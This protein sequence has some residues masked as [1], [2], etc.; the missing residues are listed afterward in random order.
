MRKFFTII[1]LWIITV[2]S[3]WGYEKQLEGQVYSDE[4]PFEICWVYDSTRS[5]R[6]ST[7]FREAIVVYYFNRGPSDEVGLDLNAINIPYKIEFIDNQTQKTFLM[8]KISYNQDP[9]GKKT[10]LGILEGNLSLRKENYE[11]IAVTISENNEK[12]V[13]ANYLLIKSDI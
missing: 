1:C 2:S 9:L 13:S 6:V 12:K 10:F 7:F 4:E 3:L 8:G 11:M 5:W